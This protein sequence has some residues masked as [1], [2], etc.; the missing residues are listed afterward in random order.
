MVQSHAGQQMPAVARRL[1]AFVRPRTETRHGRVPTHARWLRASDAGQGVVLV[2]RE[3]VLSWV[4][5]VLDGLCL[6]W[7]LSWGCSCLGVSLSRPCVL[8]VCLTPGGP[9]AGRQARSEAGAER[10]L[11]GVACT[12]L[13]D[14]A[15]SPTRPGP[16]C[17]LP[18]SLWSNS[19]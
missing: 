5:A 19:S 8:E 1:Q 16:L 18:T 14:P 3:C 9:N 11:E 15:L 7:P 13:L 12:P 4:F 2:V 6:G 17:L 10:T